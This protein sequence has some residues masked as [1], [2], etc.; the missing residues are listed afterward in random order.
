MG[1]IDAGQGLHYLDNAATAQ[2]P[3]AVID[4]VANYYYCDNANI[5][6][7]VHALSMRSTEAF[8]GVR[9]KIRG[10]LNA[11]E[12]AEIVFVRGTTE[13]INLVSNAWSV[14]EA[15]PLTP[16]DSLLVVLPMFHAFAATA[17]MLFPLLH[18]LTVVRRGHVDD[19]VGEAEL[20]VAAP[21][22]DGGHRLRR[23]RGPPGG[24][25]EERGPQRQ[26]GGDPEYRPDEQH[27]VLGDAQVSGMVRNF[28]TLDMTN[29]DNRS[30]RIDLLDLTVLLG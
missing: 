10:L 29:I 3:S 27:P 1:D 30:R 21:L 28:G 9:E 24:G 6:R 26:A 16:G 20:D 4:A 2:K 12:A 15:L 8:E 19:E 17:G 25:E 11:R 5:H 23:G 18:G 13:G 7:G 14:N 22:L